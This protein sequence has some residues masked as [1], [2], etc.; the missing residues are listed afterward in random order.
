MKRVLLI[1]LVSIF[2][3]SCT[4]ELYEFPSVEGQWV[5]TEYN[6]ADGFDINNDGEINVNLL[7]EIECFN[8]EILI[9]ESN[10]TVSSV[11]TFNPSIHVSLIETGSNDYVFDVKCDDEGS[12]GFATSFTQN[13]EIVTYNNHT[14]SLINGEL[15]VVF[16]EAFNV[17]DINDIQVLETHDIIMVYSKQ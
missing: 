15:F 11:S 5:L 2:S 10:G 17:Y 12:I 7:K 16:K 3:F 9:F 13:G 8:D 1:I 14:A 6:V 4:D